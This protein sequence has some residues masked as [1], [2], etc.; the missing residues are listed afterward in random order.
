M[1]RGQILDFYLLLLSVVRDG[2]TV[3]VRS[4]RVPGLLTRTTWFLY[5]Y[6]ITK[7]SFTLDLFVKPGR[8]FF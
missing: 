8:T 1:V 7:R 6:S 2:R 3:H 5:D 4:P